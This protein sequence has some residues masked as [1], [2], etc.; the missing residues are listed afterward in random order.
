MEVSSNGSKLFTREWMPEPSSDIRA[1]VFIS[2]GFAEHSA[3]YEELGTI[4]ATDDFLCSAHDHFGHGK[5]DGR[6]GQ[7]N[8]LQVLVDDVI[9]HCR[10]LKEKHQKKLFVLGHSM[11]GL[12]GIL[13]A[14][15]QPQLFDGLILIAPF[16]KSSNVPAIKVVLGKMVSYLIPNM[17]V[18]PALDA[19][20]ISRDEI[21]VEQ[22]RQDELNYHGGITAKTGQQF[23]YYLEI[24]DRSIDQLRTPVLCFHSKGDEIVP[25]ES[26]RLIKERATKCEDKTIIEFETGFHQLHHELPEIKTQVFSEIASWLANRT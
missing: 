24:V 26:A 18:L 5:S 13:A 11:G 23:L 22:Y 14:L 20:L 16:L 2:H 1:V 12:I 8:D 19:K 4:L 9:G 21:V 7:V 17:V 25:V 3:W 15:D 10:A 6:K